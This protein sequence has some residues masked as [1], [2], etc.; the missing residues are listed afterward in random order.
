MTAPEPYDNGG[1]LQPGVTAATNTSGQPERV[2]PGADP[3]R[4]A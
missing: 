2:V 1:V 3:D 4:E